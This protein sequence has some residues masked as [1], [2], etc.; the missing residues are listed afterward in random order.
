MQES[1]IQSFEGS[2]PSKEEM[3]ATMQR[4]GY[5]LESEVARLFVDRGYFVETNQVLKDPITGKSRELDLLAESREIN[6]V[7]GEVNAYSRIYFTCEVKNNL[8][9][10]VLLTPYHFSPNGD[11]RG[12]LKQGQTGEGLQQGL[13]LD[14]FITQWTS[15]LSDLTQFTQ[16]CSFERKKNNHKNELMAVHPEEL[17]VGLSKI[18]QACEEAVDVWRS[19]ELTN[20]GKTDRVHRNHLFLPVLIVKDQLYELSVG[21]DGGHN[22]RQ[23]QSSRLHF[24]YYYQDEARTALVYVVTQAGL[25]DFIDEMLD[26]ERKSVAYLVKGLREGIGRG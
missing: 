24:A 14:Y 21:A 12:G 3:L 6:P 23:V 20:I 2:I 16:Y 7:C 19:S 9:P 25:N 4:S 17:Y 18:T 11:E 22:F 5:L 10:I 13:D 15:T 8:Y 1:Q 26:L